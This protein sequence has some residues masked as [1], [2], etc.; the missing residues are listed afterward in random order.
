MT[1]P[2]DFVI[3]QLD[4]HCKSKFPREFAHKYSR[5]FDRNNRVSDAESLYSMAEMFDFVD[6]YTSLYSYKEWHDDAQIRKR[7]AILDTILFDLD[8]E[9]LS[10]SLKEAKKLITFLQ[11]K[12]I[13]PRVYFSGK[14]GFHVY[15]DFKEANVSIN[16]LRFFAEAV[17]GKLKLTTVDLKVIETAR[18][19]RLPF[20]IHSETRHYCT[21]LKVDKF[22]KLTVSDI[23]HISKEGIRSAEVEVGESDRLREILVKLDIRQALGEKTEKIVRESRNVILGK[24]KKKKTDWRQKRIE[25]YIEAIKKHGR[26]TADPEI[27]KIHKG[28]E[29]YARL[30]LNLLMIECGYSD[31]EIHEVFKLFKD[32]NPK[33]AEYQI[34]Y[35][36]EW[37]KRKKKSERVRA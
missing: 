35:N 16:A 1:L 7:T 23:L 12:D 24:R 32:Y 6:V 27:A 19:S 5:G 9:D 22:E 28:N 17:A 8:S 11:S 25:K 37:L 4:R 26:L 14:K 13:V 33:V 18:V 20:S 36:R 34:R 31:E 3:E 21:P 30:H 2:R 15:L 29:H 10:V